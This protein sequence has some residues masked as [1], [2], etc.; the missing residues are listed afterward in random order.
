[1]SALFLWDYMEIKRTRISY[2]ESKHHDKI[3]DYVD[4]LPFR[5]EYKE[6]IKI[7]KYFRLIFIVPDDL[8]DNIAKRFRKVRL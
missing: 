7:G 4:R 1:M 2:V 8:P 6:T 5:I 3:V